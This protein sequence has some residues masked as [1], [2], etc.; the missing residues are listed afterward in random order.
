VGPH[1]PPPLPPLCPFSPQGPWRSGGRCL[2]MP[3]ATPARRGTLLAQPENTSGSRCTV[4]TAPGGPGHST[5][6]AGPPTDNASLLLAEPPV[7]KSLPSVVMVMVNTSAVLSCEASGIPRP[8]VAWQKDGVGIAGGEREP[9][10]PAASAQGEIWVPGCCRLPSKV[11]GG[12]VH[13]SSWLPAAIQG[14]CSSC[15]S[16]SLGAPREDALL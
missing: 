9:R 12:T 2:Q 10:L 7:L 3:A 16:P 14:G 15:W 1:Q 13:G 8:E 6:P 4:R 11:L 5:R